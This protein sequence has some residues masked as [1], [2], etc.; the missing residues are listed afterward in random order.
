MAVTASTPNPKLTPAKFSHSPS[1]A[2]LL[3]GLNSSLLATTYQAGQLVSFGTHG[4]ELHVGLEPFSVAM[5]IATHP[6]RVAIGSRGLIWMMESGGR[7]LAQ[8][9]APAGKY[10][11][12][13]LTRSAHVSGNI[14]SHEMAFVGDELWVVNTLFSCLATIQP[15]YSF[16]PQWK[17]KFISNCHVPGDRCHL[18]GLAVVEGR[19]T[20]VTAM[21][22]TDTPGGWREAKERTGVLIDVASHELIA[23]GFAMPHSPR[24]HDGKIFVLDSGRGQLVTVRPQSGTWDVVATFEGYTRGLAFLGDLAFVGLSRIRETSVFGGVPIAEKREQLKCGIGVVNWRTGQHFGAFHFTS[25]VEEIFAVDVLPGGRCPVIR[26]PQPK[27]KDQVA[28]EI[29]VTPPPGPEL[30]PCSHHSRESGCVS[31]RTSATS[32]GG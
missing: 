30:D 20:Y 4:N 10:D 1:F 19:P 21:A 12:A 18:N 6:R 14:H 11:A 16:V 28:D 2:T 32:S 24:V 25:G 7:E 27:N 5:G 13:L 29:W 9:V 3:A 31:P 23:R 17:P 8:S 15:G 22:E 26:G